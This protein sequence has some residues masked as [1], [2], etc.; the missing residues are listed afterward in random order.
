MK[1]MAKSGEIHEDENQ[2]QIV[3][4]GLFTDH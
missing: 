4:N 1:N 2:V 3:N